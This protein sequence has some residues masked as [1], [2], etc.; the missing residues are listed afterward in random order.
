MPTAPKLPS[1]SVETAN[2]TSREIDSSATS[3]SQYGRADAVLLLSGGIDSTALAAL[4]RPALCVAI[5]YGQRSA[6]GELRASVAICRAL[7]LRLKTLRLDLGGLGGGLLKDEE[8][9][10]GA[11]SPEWWPYRNQ[12][13]VTAAASVAL[14]EGLSHVFVGTV[15]EDGVRHVDGRAEFYDALD[16]LVSM[17]EG[18]VRVDVPAIDQTSVEL[19]RRSGLGEDVLAWTISC[20]R[21]SFPCGDCPGCWKRG[22]VLSELGFLESGRQ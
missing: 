2:F 18:N 16:R 4:Y 6:V 11:P 1:Q 15:A 12:L 17:Q 19:V 22:R 5:D 3:D 14:G 10:P 20:H 21:A 7:S 9:V 8:A 13:L